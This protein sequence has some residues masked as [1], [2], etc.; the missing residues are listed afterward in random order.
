MTERL[1]F[2]NHEIDTYSPPLELLAANEILDRLRANDI[3][4]LLNSG[5]ATLALL[6]PNVHTSVKPEFSQLGD[7]ATTIE[8]DI[9]NLGLLL[10]FRFRFDDQAIS[11]F[12]SGNS[13][14]NQ[15]NRPPEKYP[16]FK[17][18]WDEFVHLMTSDDVQGY[19]LVAES[20][21]VATWRDQ[22]G[23]WDIENK[24]DPATLR[25]KF[26]IH[27][28]NNLLHG[29]DSTSE[30]IRELDVITRCIQR[31]VLSEKSEDFTS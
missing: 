30:A 21:A 9:K 17:S 23:S 19:I 8:Q 3:V 14:L 4:E 5:Q 13:Q 31:A 12:Y 10:K 22:V 6:R 11:E 29:S 25:G 16:H 26:G 20:G 15:M 18:R 27:N 24:S 28:Y 7:I 2:S 1:L